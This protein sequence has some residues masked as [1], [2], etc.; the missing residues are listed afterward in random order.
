MLVKEIHF[1]TLSYTHKHETKQ[2]KI[3]LHLAL[4]IKSNYL[5]NKLGEWSWEG[6]EHLRYKHAKCLI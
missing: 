4:K 2:E 1:H 6:W 3:Y 5:D